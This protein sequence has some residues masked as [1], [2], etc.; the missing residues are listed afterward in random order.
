ML[1][2]QQLLRVID[3]L[4]AENRTLLRELM[5]A[6]DQTAAGLLGQTPTAE[7]A[8]EKEMLGQ[9]VRELTTR[10][11]DLVQ[12]LNQLRDLLAAGGVAQ[13]EFEAP[14]LTVCISIPALCS[15]SLSRSLSLSPNTHTPFFRYFPLPFA[16]NLTSFFYFLFLSFSPVT[17]VARASH[18]TGPPEPAGAPADLQ[19]ADDAGAAAL[20]RRAARPAG[21][22]GTHGSDAFS[23]L[24]MQLCRLMPFSGKNTGAQ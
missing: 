1:V 11:Q 21:R 5:A 7:L 23:L 20:A 22:A 16:T 4:D 3:E 9:R 6:R 13:V 24:P 14:E 19:A 15:L 10:N 12:Q 2:K 8:V 17:P 18:S